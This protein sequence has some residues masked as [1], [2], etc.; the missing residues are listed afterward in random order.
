MI[1]LLELYVKVPFATYPDPYLTESK[2]TQLVPSFS[3]VYGMFLS[4]IGEYNIEKYIGTELSI[5]LVSNPSLLRGI[6]THHRFF[7]SKYVSS[8]IPKNIERLY[9]NK[10]CI[11]IRKGKNE[12]HE[13]SL[14]NKINRLVN[15][16]EY[17][18]RDGI[19][20]CGDSDNI[21][22]I[23]KPWKKEFA[24]KGRI[25]KKSNDA[26][27]LT[28]VWA[29]HCGFKESKWKPCI[30]EDCDPNEYPDEDCWFVIEKK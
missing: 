8:P 22:S 12:Q 4:S 3:T 20:S 17:F 13:N 29:D 5:I 18:P 19:L 24:Q 7:D 11:R 15:R 10:Y 28:T 6:V 2:E 27:F 14:V 23:I 9:D 30:L 1:E 25:I 21:V 16:E 26:D